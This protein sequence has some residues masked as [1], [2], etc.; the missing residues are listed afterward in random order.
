MATR[1]TLKGADGGKQANTAGGETTTNP[2][3]V[4]ALGRMLPDF[5]LPHFEIPTLPADTPK[6]ESKRPGVFS[7][8]D[9]CMNWV[10]EY[11][12]GNKDEVVKRLNYLHDRSYISKPINK[13]SL[14]SL[15]RRRDIPI[16]V[17]LLFTRKAKADADMSYVEANRV[18]MVGGRNGGPEEKRGP[19]KELLQLRKIL[20]K[21]RQKAIKEADK[22]N[23]G[24]GKYTAERWE[25]WIKKFKKRLESSKKLKKY[26]DLEVKFQKD[27]YSKKVKDFETCDWYALYTQ[28]VQGGK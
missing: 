18:N 9:E 23:P 13:E 8:D 2:G 10:P 25:T 15:L 7:V 20:Y 6:S 24:K 22:K 19:S 4:G 5:P 16:T 17:E 12:K 26:L 27:S 1:K 14:L 28:Q 11:I 3:E 21:E